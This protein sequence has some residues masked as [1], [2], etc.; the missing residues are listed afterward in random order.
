MSQRALAAIL[1]AAPTADQLLGLPQ[2]EL[3]RILLRAV[4]EYCNDHLWGN[5]TRDG[6][7]TL[8]FS[9]GGY[10]IDQAK[11]TAVQKA[12]NRAWKA[13]EDADLLEEPDPINGKNGYRVPTR[14]G[15][16]IGSTFDLDAAKARRRFT[17]DM[18]HPSMP[19]SSWNAFQSGDYDTAVFEAFKAVESAVR[20]KGGYPESDYG[21]ALM[22]KAFDPTTGRLIDAQAKNS[23]KRARQNLFMGAL[24]E[25][26]NPKAHGDPA[27]TDPLL[28]IQEMMTASVLLRIVPTSSD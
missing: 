10:D 12:I 6:I 13:L 9:R 17:R 5:P 2:T 28:A 14:Q 23:R 24:G 25:L 20:K 11:R 4:V 18:L 22:E 26:R 8:L 19:E 21:V 27:I 15:R 1:T 3:E 16:E 7:A